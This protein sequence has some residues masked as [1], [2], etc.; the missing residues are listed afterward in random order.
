MT[1]TWTTISLVSDATCLEILPG[2]GGRLW[3][4]THNGQSLLFK[5]EDL[6][7]S[8]VDPGDLAAL[9]TRSPQFGF[10]LWG[11]EKTWIAPDSAWR[12][13]A[14]FPVLDS[15]PYQ[16][17]SCDERHTRMQSPVCPDSGFRIDR[18]IS[19][20]HD[21]S[22]TITHDVTNCG[23][24][25]RFAGIWSVMMLK[26]PTKI[27]FECGRNP[28]FVPVFGNADGLG[29]HE[30]TFAVFDCHRRQEFKMGSSS[31]T[32]RVFMRAGHP[33]DSL[34]IVCTTTAPAPGDV[35]AH[36]HNFEVFNSG[37]YSYCEAEWHSPARTLKQ[38]ERLTYIQN[39]QIRSESDLFSGPELSPREAKF[40][41]CMS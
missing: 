23:T 7:G 18:C 5:N 20:G 9:P 11:G 27:G 25:D 35:Y 22:W 10:P 12:N 31:H 15:A 19:L 21:E 3:D 16:L 30:G 14:P 33:D 29:R 4:V 13:G 1:D 24:A 17:V 34:W 26:Q 32:G 2:I 6:I 41:S 37:D 39:F 28:A 38:G 8:R 40:L 36:G